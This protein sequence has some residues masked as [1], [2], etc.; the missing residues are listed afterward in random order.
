MFQVTH[1][2]FYASDWGIAGSYQV[3][4]LNYFL[5]HVVFDELLYLMDEQTVIKF[6]N[7]ILR[8]YKNKFNSYFGKLNNDDQ[9]LVL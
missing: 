6:K 1:P 3:E 2:H 8:T 4:T 7:K 5:L 9:F